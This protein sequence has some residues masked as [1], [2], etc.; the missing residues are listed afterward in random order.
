MLIGQQ[1][2]HFNANFFDVKESHYHYL[3][4]LWRSDYFESQSNQI[5]IPN[6]LDTALLPL[7]FLL[8]ASDE[9][10]D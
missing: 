3:L 4:K 10:I 9:V 1:P 8:H 2:K 6:M 7:E 5:V